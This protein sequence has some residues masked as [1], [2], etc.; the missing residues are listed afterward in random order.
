MLIATPKKA[1]NGGAVCNLC[2]KK[3]IQI[4]YCSKQSYHSCFASNKIN[5]PNDILN[6]L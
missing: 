3:E 4:I 2:I 5:S 1:D 6:V